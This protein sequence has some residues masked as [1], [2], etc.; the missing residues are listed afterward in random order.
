ME[1]T[2][3]ATFSGVGTTAA[4]A[5]GVWVNDRLLLSWTATTSVT[6]LSDVCS[7]SNWNVSNTCSDLTLGY[8]EP[9]V[10]TIT[11]PVLVNTSFIPF[12]AYFLLGVI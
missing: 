7:L 11:V 8:F 4:D 6:P 9:V 12:F 10:C 1:V 3:T 2:V 5:V